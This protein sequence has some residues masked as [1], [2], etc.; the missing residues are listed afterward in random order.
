MNFDEK[1]K[2]Y[3]IQARKD[4]GKSLAESIIATWQERKLQ[5][6]KVLDFGCGTG[7]VTFYL[8]DRVPHLFGY[9]PSSG[10]REQFLQKIDQLQALNVQLI[11]DLDASNETFDCIFGSLVFHHIVD[12]EETFHMLIEKLNPGGVLIVLDFDLDDGRFHHKMKDF[13]GHDGFDRTWIKVT[14]ESMGLRSVS[15]EECYRAEQTDDLGTFTYTMFC[16]V[17]EKPERPVL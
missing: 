8:R 17:G 11:D 16:G 13:K 6:E 5:P 3:D 7:L 12:V 1:A 14:F 2:N 15:V 10:M 4:R 9:D